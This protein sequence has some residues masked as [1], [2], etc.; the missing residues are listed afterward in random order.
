M[1]NKFDPGTGHKTSGPLC[2]T[3]GAIYEGGNRIPLIIRNDK[4]FPAGQTRTKLVSLNNLYATMCNDLYATMCELARVK[5]PVGSAQDSLSFGDYIPDETNSQGRR[6][7]LCHWSLDVKKGMEAG[8]QASQFQDS[9]TTPRNGTIE[10]YNLKND[11]SENNDISEREWIIEHQIGP[12]Q[13]VLREIG[14][15]PTEDRP[16][17]FDVQQLDENHGCDWFRLDASRCKE[18]LEGEMNCPS[19]CHRFKKMCKKNSMY[20]VKTAK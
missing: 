15:C 13:K 18:H 16:G 20:W 17:V 9:S 19:V 14:P 5:V 12:M 3:K 1:A 10:V 2:G 8:H 4:K 7:F 11:I 6:E